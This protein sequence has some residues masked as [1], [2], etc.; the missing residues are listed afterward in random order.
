MDG[1]AQAPSVPG[2][3]GRTYGGFA[4]GEYVVTEQPQTG[5]ISLGGVVLQDDEEE[6]CFDLV[7]QPQNELNVNTLGVSI[8]GDDFSSVEVEVESGRTVV[9]CWANM[10]INEE[11]API[12]IE[13][14]ALDVNGNLIEAGS[15]TFL[16]DGSALSPAVHGG[17]SRL[18]EVAMGE[19]VVTEQAQSG[20]SNLGGILLWDL[21]AEGCSDLVNR[22]YRYSALS[23]LDTEFLSSSVGVYAGEGTP[24]VCW[25]NQQIQTPPPPVCTNCDPG[26][27]PNPDPDPTPAPTTAPR[28]EVRGS[29]AEIKKV[30]S[31]ANPARVGERVTFTVTLTVKGDS[32]T[33]GV[34][35]V[36]TY[37][38]A[39]LRFVSSAP[40]GCISGPAAEAGKS[41]VMCALP[42]MVPGTAGTSQVYML[43][44][45]A[46]AP[47]S[48]TV[49]SVVAKLDLDGTG[50]AVP[51]TIGPATDSVSIIALP[52][53]LPKAGD[54]ELVESTQGMGDVALRWLMFSSLLGFVGAAMVAFRGSRI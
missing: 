3:S 23:Y 8:E 34:S 11:T 9:V 10:R 43:T 35:L 25:Y 49:D 40:A 47:T 19:H 5:W 38:N 39:Y 7:N 45:D 44:F 37:E 28:P 51:A 21:E 14:V 15:F 18:F 13:K 30:L 50:P 53:A 32:T 42:D 16:L 1:T 4:P 17:S 33:T 52:S 24:T 12:R 41:Q 36:D 31:S 20:W 27:T 46:L 2:G 22:E 26:P 54:G 29:S 6:S 48:R